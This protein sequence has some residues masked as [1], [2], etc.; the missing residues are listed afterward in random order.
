M[1]QERIKYLDTMRAIGL[2]LVIAGHMA[3]DAS[4][5][6]FIYSFHMPLFFFVSGV[7]SAHIPQVSL[8]KFLRK[9]LLAYLV[10]FLI[11]YLYFYGNP[12]HE[13]PLS[14][15]KRLLYIRKL[16]PNIA[17]WYIPLYALVYTLFSLLKKNTVLTY[18]SLI[19]LIIITP[20]FQKVFPDQCILMLGVLPAGTA[21]ML[22]GYILSKFM[23]NNF[24]VASLCFCLG[25][26]MLLWGGGGHIAGI[27]SPVYFIRALLFIY[28]IFCISKSIQSHA[29]EW[30]GKNSLPIFASHLI[31]IDA[32][33]KSTIYNMAFLSSGIMKHI[34]SVLTIA[35]LSAIFA[36]LYNRTKYLL[37]TPSITI[38][39]FKHIYWSKRLASNKNE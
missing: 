16:G 13:E 30:F 22:S 6:N 21:F 11:S 2:F 36:F 39:T 9:I 4:E 19:V 14:L 12:F 28:P 37:T 3:F 26:Y 32:F 7:L 17:L 24:Y 38:K 31:F 10:F 25:V 8:I 34:Y 15:L 23:K 1:T 20:S 29:L 27:S 33:Q 5:T 35:I 18:F